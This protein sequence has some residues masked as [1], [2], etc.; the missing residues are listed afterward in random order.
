M[1]TTRELKSMVDESG[2]PLQQ[3]LTAT[4]DGGYNYLATRP[5]STD[6]SG[7]KDRLEK[8]LR[9]K[10]Y[11]AAPW[12]QRQGKTQ[13]AH[14]SLLAAYRMIL[15]AEV[16][17]YKA[18][19]ARREP[20]E[21]TFVVELSDG[22]RRRF[23]EMHPA[24]DWAESQI[25]GRPGAWAAFYRLEGRYSQE[26][27]HGLETNEHGVVHVARLSGWEGK[28]RVN[29]A[30]GGGG[31]RLFVGVYPTGIVYADRS[32]EEHGDYKRLAFL[33]YRTLE[34]EWSKGVPADLKKRIESDAR[35]I[36]ARRGEEFQVST[37]GQ[38]VRLGD[39]PN[40]AGGPASSRGTE[41]AET[42][43]Q[44]LGGTRRL[45]AMI[46]AYGFVGGADSLHFRFK[47]RARDGINSV[48]IVLE[49][50]DTY[51]VEFWSIRGGATRMVRAFE[52]VYADGLRGLLERETGL[53]LTM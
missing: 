40:R 43:V 29:R 16:A 2:R 46:G 10:N 13:Q 35:V 38:T 45:S 7:L 26:P 17:A 8:R 5:I 4:L 32:R 30:G 50:S 11:G 42:I 31:D 52:Q 23:F 25:K 49:P 27:F 39:G 15:D 33:P 34:L 3:R 22:Q 18:D 37:A 48:R 41:V 51:R 12:A 53:Y 21:G 24:A 14:D 47:A 20:T 19:L 36:Q 9:M 1:T 28:T 44:Q 6:L